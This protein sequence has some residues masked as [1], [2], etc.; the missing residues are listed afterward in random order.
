MDVLDQITKL[1]RGVAESHGLECIDTEMFRAGRRRVLR[2]YIG[3]ASGVSVEDCAKVSREMSAVLDAEDWLGGD[4]YSLEISSPGL[5]RPLKTLSDWKRN[6]GRNVVVFCREAVAG[7]LQHQGKLTLVN[8][9]SVV[10]TIK[11]ETLPIPLS[12]VSL[13][14]LE[15]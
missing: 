4:A 14:K 3:K 2:V 7:K 11:T 13:A 1:A 5:D 12:Q 9:D 6:L 10:L 8:E 15:I